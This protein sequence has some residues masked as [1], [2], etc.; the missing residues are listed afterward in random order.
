MST[1][2]SRIDGDSRTHRRSSIGGRRV[3]ELAGV[4]IDDIDLVDL[5]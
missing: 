4:T 2:T 1:P 5:Y 3:L